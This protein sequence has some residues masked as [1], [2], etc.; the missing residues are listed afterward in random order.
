MATAIVASAYGGPDVLSA[1]EASVRQPRQGEATIR[2]K[3]A[4]VNPIDYKLYSGVFG[5]NPDSLPRRLGQELA[6]VVTAVGPDASGP[7][8]EI[9]VGDEVI[10]YGR[11]VS[12]AYA[13]ELTVP[14]DAVLPKPATLSWEQASGLLLTGVTAVHTLAATGVTAGDTVLI[15]GSA[16]GVGLTAA[17]LAILRGAQVIGT[18][19]EARH[20][21]LRHYG[22]TPVAY[23]PGL[24]DRVRELAPGG[25]D[26][27]IDTIGTDEAI[28]VSLELVPDRDRIATIAG[29]HRAADSG[30]KQLGSAPGADPGTEIRSQA[31][32]ELVSLAAD[33]K[34]DVV[35][36]ATFPLEEAAAAHELVAAGHAGGKVVLVP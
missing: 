8:G 18:A 16:G 36:A 29:F 10:A 17:Q 4:A 5:T 13:T 28:D 3:A 1:V 14:A 12:G 34:L 11:G 6:G 24:A 31:R 15:H 21:R 2:V 22:V 25:I 33:G 30:I 19:S 35:V 26:A 23:G 9:R 27:A 20:E 7:A 32:S